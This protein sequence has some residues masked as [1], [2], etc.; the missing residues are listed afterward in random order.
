MSLVEDILR[1]FL[2]GRSGSYKEIRRQLFYPTLPRYEKP[3]SKEKTIATILWRL[4]KQ[5]LIKL[6]GGKLITTLRGKK[7]LE[8]L[9]KREK[10]E[11]PEYGGYDFDQLKNR[12]IWLIVVFDIPIKH[13]RKRR[14]L[15]AELRILDFQSLQHSVW[16]GRG[17]LPEKFMKKIIDFGIFDFIH[18]FEIKKSGTVSGSD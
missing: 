9:A 17:P 12:K 15:R 11:H 3:V 10:N 16:I 18:I 4:K 8:K 14:W 13:N 6:E 7:H 2:S 1:V 5:E